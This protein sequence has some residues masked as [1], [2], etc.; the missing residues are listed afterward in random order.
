MLDR[1]KSRNAEP[2]IVKVVDLDEGDR[3]FLA[4]ILAITTAKLITQP[5][6]KLSSALAKKWIVWRTKRNEGISISHCFGEW[7]GA[8]V[9][10]L[11]CPAPLL[12]PRPE[13]DWWRENY[14]V[15]A[16]ISLWRSSSHPKIL[17]DL[18]SGTGLLA[19]GIA[20]QLILNQVFP[21][22]IIAV[23]SS[24][25]ACE[26]IKKN[27]E[28]WG[29]PRIE[30][31]VRQNS[32]DSWFDGW[33][34]DFHPHSIVV[35][36]PPYLDIAWHDPVPTSEDKH[37]LYAG[38]EGCNAIKAILKGLNYRNWRGQGWIECDPRPNYEYLLLDELSVW[39]KRQWLKDQWGRRRVLFIQ[40]SK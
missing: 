33:E 19:I 11:L 36:N 12:T 38:D 25:L 16:L 26:T 3:E 35:S 30:F 9:S 7:P 37:A 31:V 15:P 17:I 21:H 32:I 40:N 29:D 13:T 18:G 2:L 20:R 34:N 14:V 5:S 4:Q 1:R 22:K 27:W 8:G 28:R 23:D 6:W 24:T 10:S 39:K